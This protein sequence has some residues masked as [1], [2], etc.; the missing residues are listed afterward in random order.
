MTV[1]L[2]QETNASPSLVFANST[3]RAFLSFPPALIKISWCPTQL[4]IPEKSEKIMS[5]KSN[6]AS[7]PEVC[8]RLIP[9]IHAKIIAI[10]ND[11]NDRK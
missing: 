6:R 11:P 4:A 9:K 2:R 8:S 10:I 3:F 1:S 5:K 7:T